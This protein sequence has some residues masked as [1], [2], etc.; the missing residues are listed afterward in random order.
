MGNKN[1]RDIF[2]VAVFP[3][4]TIILFILGAVIGKQ[5]LIITACFTL[6][7]SL[8]MQFLIMRG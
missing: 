2:G 7:V 3:I 8:V 1:L 6:C 5:G 4:I